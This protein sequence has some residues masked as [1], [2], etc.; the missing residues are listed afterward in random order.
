[1]TAA[2]RPMS[3]RKY[4][5]GTTTAALLALAERCEAAAGPDYQ[6]GLAIAEAAGYRPVPN[7]TS[8]GGLVG[9]WYDPDGCMTT[10]EGPPLFTASVDAALTLVPKGWSKRQYGTDG[11][12]DS[13]C[14]ATLTYDALRFAR[15]KTEPL[16][17]CA[18]A[19]RARAAQ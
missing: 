15:A 14:Y 2:P 18:A 3:L 13:P 4:P 16:A 8:A 5:C 6:M 11:F 1:M 12:S 9:R 10:H 19:L 17:I 7:P